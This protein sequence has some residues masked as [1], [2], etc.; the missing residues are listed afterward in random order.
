[1]ADGKIDW[2]GWFLQITT[3]VAAIIP[4]YVLLRQ[5]PA[6]IQ[7][8]TII[9]SLG[10]ILVALLLLAVFSIA[11]KW[12]KMRKDI[13]DNIKE[14]KDI[15]GQLDF[16]NLFNDLKHKIN[17][18]EQMVKGIKNKKGQLNIDPRIIIWIILMFLLYLLLKSMGTPR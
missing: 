10:V 7:I 13:D 11:G 2:G 14:V 3:L 18:V 8:Q 6:Q 12:S 5:S 15:K 9:Y 1:M 4:I 17:S 16:H